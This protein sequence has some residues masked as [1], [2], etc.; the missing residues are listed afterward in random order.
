MMEKFNVS[1]KNFPV[2]CINTI[3][4]LI[5]PYYKDDD[6]KKRLTLKL[7]YETDYKDDDYSTTLTYSEMP[8]VVKTVDKKIPVIEIAKDLYMGFNLSFDRT[9]KKAKEY[10]ELPIKAICLQFFHSEFL[11]AKADWAC[12]TDN[13]AEDESDHPQ[14]HWHFV[15]PSNENLGVLFIPQTKRQNYIEFQKQEE[16]RKNRFNQM[17]AE[18]E[19]QKN[20]NKGESPM[21]ISRMHFAMDSEWHK[22][23][24][25]ELEMNNDNIRNWLRNCIES[26]ISEH[27]FRY[28]P[29]K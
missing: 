3:T 21:D 20:N 9:D 29:G 15:Y 7:T 16:E 24:V 22:D 19:A 14:P 1:I 25:F 23:G 18:I 28:K 2:S 11:F 4:E 26:V 10:K 12:P 8:M 6:V 27:R 13:D 17:L 5:K